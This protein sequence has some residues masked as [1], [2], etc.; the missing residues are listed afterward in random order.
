MLVDIVPLLR[1]PTCQTALELVNIEEQEESKDLVQ[2]TIK[3]QNNHSWPIENGV[4]AFSR[5]DAPS[6]PWSKSFKEFDA[7]IENKRWAVSSF[8][9]DV[10]HIISSI[11]SNTPEPYLDLCTGDGV[12]LFNLLDTMNASTS[13]I[14][15]DMSL[16]AQKYNRR[17]T[18]EMEAGHPI[19]FIASDASVLPIKSDTIPCV[20]S[21]AMANM[22]G[23]MADGVNEA[24]RVLQKGGLFVF[25]HMFVDE[26]SE[27][28]RILN[29]VLAK[30]GTTDHGYLGLQNDFDNLMGRIG[31]SK[32][33]VSIVKEVIGDPNR[34]TESGPIFPYPNERMQNVLV[35][36]W[37]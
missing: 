36:A 23:K 5:E 27:G 19:N 34:D 25:T 1:C 26:D 20:I 30:Y 32:Y 21:F 37:K 33:D 31:F 24:H 10:A 9:T 6:D 28:W 12:L 2:G 11:P 29:E 17:Y 7:F 14:S 15:I 16:H 22:M 13:L 8:A 35:K 3:C 4:L 18:A